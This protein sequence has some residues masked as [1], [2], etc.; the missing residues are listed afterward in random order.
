M[1]LD[2]V[3]NPKQD[4]V[5]TLDPRRRRKKAPRQGGSSGRSKEVPRPYKERL[6]RGIQ[7]VLFLLMAA[8]LM[9]LCGK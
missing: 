9:Q 4:N 8:Y 7:I 3:P 1:S 6:G 5:L 2:P